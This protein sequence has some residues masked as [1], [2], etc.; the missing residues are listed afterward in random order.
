MS[1]TNIEPLTESIAEGTLRASFAR[2]GF[3]PDGRAA[4]RLVVLLLSGAGLLH[5]SAVGA[6]QP[7]SFSAA[8]IDYGD[9]R[10]ERVQG[11]LLPDG[12]FTIAFAGMTGPG[13]A[14]LRD[15]LTVTGA[16]GP[17][18]MSDG[19]LSL[20]STLQVRGLEASVSVKSQDGQLVLD[21]SATEQQLPELGKWPGMPA[22][23][24]W[25]RSGLV[26][27]HITIK[28]S[29]NRPTTVAWR[30][31]VEHLAF[32]SP[33]G[34][35][36]GEDLRVETTGS[37][38]DIDVPALTVS[39]AVRGGELLID[40]F[41]RDFS[42]ASLGYG[43]DLRWS[44]EELG[45]GRL[46]LGDGDAMSI[47]A[48][49]RIALAGDPSDWA[50]EVTG[51]Q[52]DFPAAYKRYMEP[53]AAAWT[54]NGLEVTGRLRWSGEWASG[55]LVSGNLEIDDFS[56]VD[57]R[58]QRFAVTGLEARLRPGDYAF[59]SKLS[60]RGL[61][62][63]RINLG[64]GA[65]AL[66]SEPGAV[67]L[68]EPLVLDVLGG[69]VELGTLKLILPGGRADGT[70]QP[71]VLLRARI[72]GLDMAQLTEALGWPSFNGKISGEIPGVSLDEG[73]LGVDGEIFFDVFGG[74]IALQNLSMERV[75]GV[76]PSLSADVSVA[77]LD[78]E[79]LTQT[80]S[81]GRIAGRLDGYVHD[82]RML[83]WK[84]VAFD[85]WLGT[86]ERQVGSNDISRQAVNRLTTIGG[87]SATAALTGPL[88]RMF[89]S[90]SYRRLGLGCHL[91]G[92]VCQ[93]RGLS[94]DEASVLILE[95][96]G[97]PKITIRAFNRNIDWPQMVA[98]LLSISAE[99]PVQIGD[100]PD[101]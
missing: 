69:H 28:Q 1:K 41:Y 19:N 63:G 24:T 38:P 10:F 78:L 82:L 46:T 73:V 65:A 2:L 54:L 37:W 97:V 5:G 96:A 52:L 84:P 101:S 27:S 67:A 79:Q 31:G 64:A 100:Q 23:M 77:D 71:D 51:L 66:D 32:D 94:E 59:D 74:R 18:T 90:F 21:L 76:L 16:L 22:E 83:D 13:D 48:R 95:G 80:F 36:A 39:G 40:D 17:V 58:R 12:V 4:S 45:I 57:S 75:F 29:A 33:E 49:A 15:G 20:N 86:P 98:N 55:D 68:L 35:Y 42:T 50:L 6:V 61:L 43:A 92:N 93:L 25:L 88:M 56:I 70:G 99:S 7:I 89:S 62:L 72:S 53:M 44:N 30:L 47:E 8:S 60:W 85:A 3:R 87:G 81:F 91:Q 11:Q 34:R 26:D 14:Y 9:L